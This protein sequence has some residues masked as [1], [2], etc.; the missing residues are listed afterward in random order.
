MFVF[1]WEAPHKE[2]AKARDAIIAHLSQESEASDLPLAEAIL[3]ELLDNVAR[4]GPKTARIAAFWREDGAAVVEILEISPG[5][6]PVG[7]P[8][9]QGWGIML[10]S[11]MVDALTV[12]PGVDGRGEHVRAVLPM[13]R[14]ESP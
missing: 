2:A 3:D 13:K 12:S 4:L 11:A 10:A 5:R 9:T 8:P 6:D 7:V 14:R 1:E